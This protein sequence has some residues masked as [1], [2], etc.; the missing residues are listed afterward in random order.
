MLD[1]FSGFKS[2]IF[3]TVLSFKN[4]NNNLVKRCK[5][6][7]KIKTQIELKKDRILFQKKKNKVNLEEK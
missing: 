3:K 7:F 2:S 6:L 5:R 4:I 1:S